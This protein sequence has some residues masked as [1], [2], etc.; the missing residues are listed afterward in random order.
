MS[1]IP[2]EMSPPFIT[3]R[4]RLE[5]A[6]KSSNPDAAV[7]EYFAEFLTRKVLSTY[8]YA[9][10]GRIEALKCNVRIYCPQYLD[11]LDKL[12]VLM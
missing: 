1:T 4:D 11:M 3:I 7:R 6:L 9:A 10:S 8:V 5:D 2:G 12:M